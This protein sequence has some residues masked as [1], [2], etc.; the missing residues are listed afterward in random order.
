MSN[1]KLKAYNVVEKMH[2]TARENEARALSEG[3]LRLERVLDDWD[4]QD[5]REELNEAL[6]FNQRI[7]TIFQT[8][9]VADDCP[10]PLEL[11]RNMLQLSAFI[12]KQ[13][14]KAMASPLPGY[15]TPIININR[16]LAKGLR[17]AP[18]KQYSFRP[19][20]VKS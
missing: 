17:A 2:R 3:A 14:F 7:W 11:R 6:R 19:I 13:I 5:K 16:G 10:L 1:Y 18:P 12:D 4:P 20:Q 15:V 9:V 8:A